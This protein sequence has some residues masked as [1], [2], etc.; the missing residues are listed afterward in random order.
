MR[1][2][3]IVL[4]ICIT[5]APAG[6]AEAETDSAR[7]NILLIVG[8]DISFGD[9]GISGSVTR[10]PN[11]DR[12]AKRGTFFTNFPEQTRNRPMGARHLQPGV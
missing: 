7:P 6:A 10:T 9:L 2:Y 12:L 8:D 5:L 1:N 11:L 3:L 4:L